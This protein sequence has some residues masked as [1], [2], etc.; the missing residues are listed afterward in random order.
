MADVLR[1]GTVLE[2]RGFMKILIGARSDEILGFTAF[3]FGASKLMAAQTAMVGQMPH[4]T[5]RD[6][7]FTHPTVSEGLILSRASRRSSRFITEDVVAAGRPRARFRPGFL[8]QQFG[9]REPPGANSP[10]NQLQRRATPRIVVSTAD[11][12]PYAPEAISR[13]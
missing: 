10:P 5:L 6:A 1:T 13:R 3:A 11:P 12:R 8:R 2:P 9:P 4:T 7:I